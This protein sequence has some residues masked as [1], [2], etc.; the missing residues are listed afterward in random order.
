MQLRETILRYE[1]QAGLPSSKQLLDELAARAA[2]QQQAGGQQPPAQ[3][4]AEPA[5]VQVAAVEQQG[6]TEDQETTAEAPEAGDSSL[7]GEA[8]VAVSPGPLAAASRDEL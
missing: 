4:V 2:Q 6:A 1:Q 3:Q 7:S 8:G 5:G